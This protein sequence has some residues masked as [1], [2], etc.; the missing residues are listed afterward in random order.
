M[1]ALRTIDTTC[2][3]RARAAAWDDLWHRSGVDLP[4]KRAVMLAQWVDHFAPRARFV[5]LAV[6]DSGE[7][8]AALPLVGTRLRGVIPAAALPVNSFASGGDLLLDP[9]C[10]RACVLACLM[11]GL[12]RLSWPVLWIDTI[13][14]EEARWKAFAAAC[15]QAGLP[16]QTRRQFDVGL[17]DVGSDWQA[18]KSRWSKN[19]R[20]DMRRRLN[21]ARCQGELRLEV[22]DSLAS[23]QVERYLTIAWEVEDKSWKGVAGTSVLRTPGSRQFYLR[24]ARQLADWGQLQISFLHLNDRPIAFEYGYRVN[25]TYFSHKVGY[26][27]ACR[28]L[29]PGQLLLMMLL[30]RDHRD[31]GVRLMNSMGIITKA[32][33]KWCTK[34]RPIGRILVGLGGPVG[35]ACVFGYRSVWPAMNRLRTRRELPSFA[36]GCRPALVNEKLVVSRRAPC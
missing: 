6:E 3:L 11:E 9:S 4:T 17:I 1:Y 32:V 29:A 24:Q 10:D 15:R 20:K 22:Y 5:T 27:D 33:A 13:E 31:P 12:H 25:G 36:P 7:L 2:E 19:H 35:S 8:V 21:R 16:I 14:L 28:A 18:Y 34:A 30:E 23:D 26:D